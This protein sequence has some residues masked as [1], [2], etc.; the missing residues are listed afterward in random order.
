MLTLN[1]PSLDSLSRFSRERGEVL[2]SLLVR[3]ELYRFGRSL[4]ETC[5]KRAETMV[6]SL[7]GHR[8]NV[9]N[10]IRSHKI[11]QGFLWMSNAQMGGR[12]DFMIYT[13]PFRGGKDL[14]K[15]RLLEVRDS[16][17]KANIAGEFEGSY[18][19]TVK[20][21][22][23]YRQ[24]S[25]PESP[26]RGELRGLWQME[27][28]AMMGGPFVLQAYHNVAD[29][30]VYVIDVFVYKPNENK[31]NLIR[32]MEAALYTL[33][34]SGEEEFQPKDILGARYTRATKHE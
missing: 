11:G 22:L 12:R 18:P 5:S 6:D 34:P 14:S 16:V 2:T 3:H 21:G 33:R 30:L 10:D 4:V 32:G 15:E 7:F 8:V 9:P 23:I 28:G 17:L 31:L 19:S 20:T 27:G 24:V 29:N 1:T 26:E 13:F 25:M